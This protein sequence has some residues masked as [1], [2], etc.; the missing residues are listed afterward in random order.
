L[1]AHRAPLPPL[2]AF[3]CHGHSLETITGNLSQFPHTRTHTHTPHTLPLH[4]AHCTL[5][6]C[7][8]TFSPLGCAWDCGTGFFSTQ[9][10]AHPSFLQNL[11]PFNLHI[12]VHT[13]FFFF[14][15]RTRSHCSTTLCHRHRAASPP[16]HCSACHL[17][18]C[19]A[20]CTTTRTP[21]CRAAACARCLVLTCGHVLLSVHLL[22]VSL[23]ATFIAQPISRIARSLHTADNIPARNVASHHDCLAIAPRLNAHRSCRARGGVL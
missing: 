5:P 22:Y 20:H 6:F 10:P 8:R 4:T 12:S 17:S 3:L 19:P 13:H 11:L 7:T 15:A 18:A 23:D 21:P 9:L 2:P 16:L 14:V 1:V